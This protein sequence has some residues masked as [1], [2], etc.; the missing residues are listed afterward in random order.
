MS[1]SF[2]VSAKLGVELEAALEAEVEKL[3]ANQVSDATIEQAEAAVE[4]VN[5]LIDSGVLGEVGTAKKPGMRFTVSVSGHANPDH[6]PADGMAN[7]SV[8]ITISQYT[9]ALPV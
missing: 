1:Y 6:K 5:T 7:D 9:A 8:N 3:R 4:A 2:S